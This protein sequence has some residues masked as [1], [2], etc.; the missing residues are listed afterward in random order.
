MNFDFYKIHGSGNDLIV[1]DNRNKVFPDKD[2]RFINKICQNHTGIG[3]DGLLLLEKS[4]RADF[5]MRYFNADGHESTMCVNGSRCICYYAFLLKVIDKKHSFEAGDGVHSAEILDKLRVKVEV[6]HH[7]NTDSRTF[8]VDFR[9][10]NS[11]SFVNFINTGVPHLVL[12][13]RD[14]EAV[15]VE[16]LGRELRFHPYYAPAG[17]NIN[18]VEYA[19]ADGQKLSVRTYERG[20]E[21]ET[22]SCGSGVTAAALSFHSPENPAEEGF[23]VITRG[24]ELT[25]AFNKTNNRIFL[26]GPVNIIYQGKY[27][28]EE[29]Q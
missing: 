22:L 11:I 19:A 13:C 8:P 27:I 9:L 2:Y 29:I 16:T 18:F 17:A 14:I 23:T 5:R 24:G 21:A 15:P 6:K 20:V 1:I 10:P 26:E 4:K 3:A 25:V 28:E 7:K 12:A